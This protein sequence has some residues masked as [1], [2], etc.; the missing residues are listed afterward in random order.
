MASLVG[1][2]SLGSEF[3]SRVKL[4]INEILENLVPEMPKKSRFQDEY[5]TL[6]SL[7]DDVN[8]ALSVQ[9]LDPKNPIKTLQKAPSDQHPTLDAV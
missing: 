1:W 8:R 7:A 4:K 6:T 5:V 3:F 9:F 2:D